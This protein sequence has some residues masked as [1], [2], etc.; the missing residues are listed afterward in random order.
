MSEQI[1]LDFSKRARRSDPET[2]KDA[3][4]KAAKFIGGHKRRI[5]DYLEEIHPWSADYIQIAKET[6][7]TEVQVGRRLVDLREALLIECTGT[8]PIPGKD[9]T[10][11]LWKAKTK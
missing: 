9:T 7:L 1:V 5:L 6:G 11:Q 10:A 2:S 3:A 8:H 4:R